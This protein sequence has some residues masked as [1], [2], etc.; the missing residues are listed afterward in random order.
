MRDIIRNHNLPV[1][2][3]MGSLNM[4]MLTCVPSAPSENKAGQDG[5]KTHQGGNQHTL[6][7]KEWQGVKCMWH[8]PA[9]QL[10]GGAG[11]YLGSYWTYRYQL[12]LGRLLELPYENQ[13]SKASLGGI[14]DS[15][16]YRGCSFPQCNNLQLTLLPLR[17]RIKSMIMEYEA[18][19]VGQ[20][21]CFE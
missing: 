3:T 9:S 18:E 21:K 19:A 16:T 11:K 4:I 2:I 8:V 13:M 14:K 15:W 12:L 17:H 20:S 10:C 5:R 1:G 6:Q 7:S